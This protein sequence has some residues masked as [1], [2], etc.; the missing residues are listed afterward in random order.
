RPLDD[1]RFAPRAG[2]AGRPPP[3]I[4]PAWP[5][6]VSCARAVVACFRAPV[7]LLPSDGTQQ[8][9]VQPP[10]ARGLPRALPGGVR[11]DARELL[12]VAPADAQPHPDRRLVLPG[13]PRAGRARAG[14]LRGRA[15]LPEAGG[16]GDRAG[17]R[18]RAPD[19]LLRRARRGRA[20]A[21]G[22]ARPRRA[23]P[24][25]PGPAT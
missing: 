9:V 14:G 1:K 6:P 7:R 21:P 12:P 10:A 24:D 20:R 11:G 19:P 18:R 5:T 23:P 3:L 22:R 16:P 13:R 17:G 2:I 4:R 25:P 8:R 15:P